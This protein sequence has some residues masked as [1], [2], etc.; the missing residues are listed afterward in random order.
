VIEASFDEEEF[1]LSGRATHIEAPAIRLAV[2][3][4]R[5]AILEWTNS[6]QLLLQEG[7]YLLKHATSFVSYRLTTIR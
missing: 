4:R 7:R 6:T 5:Q 3:S 2:R 1:F